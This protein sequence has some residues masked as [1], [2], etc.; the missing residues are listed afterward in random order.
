VTRRQTKVTLIHH[1]TAALHVDGFADSDLSDLEGGIYLGNTY[2]RVMPSS[3]LRVA[4]V[5]DRHPA[6]EVDILDLRLSDTKHRDIYKTIEWENQYRIRVERVGNPFDYCNDRIEDADW[7]GLSSHFTFESG[8]IR[9]LIHHLKKTKPQ[10]KIMVGGADVKARPSDYIAFGA[11]LAFVGDCDPNVIEAYRGGKHVIAHRPSLIEEFAEPAFEKL[12]RLRDYVESYDGPVP[13]GVGYPI[14]YMYLSRGC[15]RE[16]DFCETRRTKF[17]RLSLDQSL[18]ALERYRSAGITTLNFTDDNLLL[19]AAKP[20]G[21]SDLI[22]LFKTMRRMGFAWEFPIGL[23]IGRFIKDGQVD[24]E[25]MEVMFD[26]SVDT[27]T[28]RFTGAYR[29]YV[30]LETFERREHYKKLRSGT[31]QNKVLTWLAGAGLPEID[32]GVV[33][34]PSAT[35]E[36]FSATRDG[37]LQVKD[38]IHSN[39]ATKAR[40]AAFHLIPIALFRAMQTKYTI[41]EFPEAWNLYFPNYDGDHFTGRELFERRLKLIKEIDPPNFRNMRFGQYT[42]G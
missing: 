6:L 11:D 9:D 28:G 26:H 27:A 16:C 19:I 23:E 36:T 8:I 35:E 29:M 24:E 31:E 38:I 39:G 40:Y 21:R 5:L 7:V 18:V 33:L 20:S 12:P 32:F 22:E 15:P 3:L 17:D 10:I 42:Y 30:P 25:L 13:K 37:Y 2:E 4:S 41:D 14:G 34:P 1:P